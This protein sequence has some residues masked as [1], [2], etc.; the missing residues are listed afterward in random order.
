MHSTPARRRYRRLF[1]IGLVLAALTSGVLAVGAAADQ[2]S[3]NLDTTADA[4]AEVM[5][6]TQGGANGTTHLY[7][8]TENGDGKNGCNFNRQHDSHDLIG[9]ERCVGRN[10]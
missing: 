4:V 3:N 1:K 8:V 6:L 2:I 9:F 5:P 7:V 10:G